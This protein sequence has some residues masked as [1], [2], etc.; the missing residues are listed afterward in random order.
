MPRPPQVTPLAEGL[1]SETF[2]A[3]V[4][5]EGRPDP[6]TAAF[7]RAVEQGFYE[8]WLDGEVLDRVVPSFVADG[9]RLTGVYAEKAGLPPEIGFPADHPVGTFV[10]YD[11]TLNAGSL[12]P[13]RLITGV[14]VDPGFRRRGILKHLMTDALARAVADGMPMAAL[15]ASEGAIYGRFGFGVAV[16]EASVRL[17]LAGA[18]SSGAALRTPPAGRVLPADPTKLGPVIE[19]V[20]AADHAATRG[21]VERQDIVRDL[22]AGRMT[23]FTDTSWNRA[24]RAAV[25]VRDDGSIGGYVCYQ[26]AGWE[27][28]PS[29]MRVVDMAAADEVSRLELWR[30]LISLDVVDRV[31]QRTAPVEDPLCRALVDPRAYRVS[32]IRDMLWLRILDV[33]AALAARPW[34]GDGELRL[35]VDDS[36]GIIDGTYRVTV[37]GGAAEVTEQ[38]DEDSADGSDE[39]SDEG[40]PRIRTDAE[41]LAAL[42]LGDVGLGALAAAGRLRADSQEHL[43]AAAALTDLT[44]RPHC[45]THF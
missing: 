11:K 27:T 28:E 45:A 25:H 44:D 36:L 26:H 9:Q 13:T 5:A 41:T 37:R 18:E 24:R 30:F 8:P 14:T 33:P 2:A 15:T 3:G 20:A 31:T 21:S 6:R 1:R 17:D 10:D 22:A 42:Y 40:L 32:G 39:D 23:S 12:L 29:T 38:R 7:T 16:R 4:D 43:R 19:E 34:V 35:E